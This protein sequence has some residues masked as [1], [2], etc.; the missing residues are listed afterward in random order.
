MSTSSPSSTETSAVGSSGGGRR[1][2]GAIDSSPGTVTTVAGAVVIAPDPKG[3][4]VAAGAPPTVLTEHPFRADRRGEHV[5]AGVQVDLG[6]HQYL[7]VGH[8]LGIDLTAPADP[9]LE[10]G[11]E[12]QRLR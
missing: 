8:R 9:G 7:G 6:D 1:G 10:A 11:D 12:V 3:G 2:S 5:P 4:A